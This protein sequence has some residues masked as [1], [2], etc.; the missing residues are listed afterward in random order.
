M[1]LSKVQTIGLLIATVFAIQ[2]AFTPMTQSLNLIEKKL[3]AKKIGALLLLLKTRKPKFGILPLPLPVPIP[4][5]IDL[6]K[7]QAWPVP[8][9][10]PAPAWPAPE[11]SWPAPEPSWPA[12]SSGGYGDLGGYDAGSYESAGGWGDDAGYSNDLGGS[13]GGESSGYG[14]ESS[15]YGGASGAGG[16]GANTAAQAWA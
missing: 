12:P 5:P 13:Y 11:P 2:L 8:V 15:G 6:E 4:I 1:Q 3:A 10:H 16:Y 14:G 9:H 7:K